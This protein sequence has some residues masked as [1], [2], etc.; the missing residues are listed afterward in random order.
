MK[1]NQASAILLAIVLFA[2]GVASG[3][4]GQRYFEKSVVNA[5]TAEDFRQH[6]M[7]EMK[8]KL[9]LTPG[10]VNQLEVILDETKARYKGVRDQYHPAMMQIKQEQISRVK[11]VLTP[12]QVPAYEQLIAERERRFKDQEERDRQEDL[13]RAA[14]H[15]V[16]AGR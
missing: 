3:V 12:Q 1:R 9:K 5:K 6:Y 8:V 14:A 11:A 4:L 2:S 16:R 10:Q 7:S 15:R 13:K